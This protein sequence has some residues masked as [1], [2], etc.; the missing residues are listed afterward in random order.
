MGNEFL[1]IEGDILKELGKQQE[2]KRVQAVKNLI[3][4][5]TPPEDFGGTIPVRPIRGGGRVEYVPGWWMIQQLNALF[6]YNW[7]FE[8]INQ[9]VGKH[10]VWVLG[11]LTIR[12]GSITICKTQFG[13]SDIKKKKG[14]DE[15]IDIA[16][17]LKSAA[18]DSLKKCA[19]QLGLAADIY[20]MREQL[21]EGMASKA[22]LAALF[23]AGSEKGMDEAAVISLAE[24][25]YGKKPEDL[26]DLDILG[27]IQKVREL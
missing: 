20:G 14:S 3:G 1:P 19:T 7:D 12:G 4:G 11:R 13:G 22:Q 17:D 16:D 25:K 24:E 21:E 2:E 6:N 15:V 27:L 5:K 26:E 9:E 18:T 23:T 10:Q 8:V